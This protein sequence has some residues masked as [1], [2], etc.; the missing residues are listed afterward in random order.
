M[1]ILSAPQAK[2]A[3]PDKSRGKKFGN[4]FFSPHYQNTYKNTSCGR[5]NSRPKKSLQKTPQINLQPDF[6]RKNVCK[7]K[8]FQSHIVALLELPQNKKKII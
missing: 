7:S 5:K 2:I 3:I 4:E 6:R 1:L 8:I